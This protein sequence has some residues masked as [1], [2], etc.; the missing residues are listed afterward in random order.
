VL[1]F[2]LQRLSVQRLHRVLHR[3][4]AQSKRMSV[5]ARG[6]NAPPDEWGG[7]ALTDEQK[8]LWA[9]G[10]GARVRTLIAL[11]RAYQL[12]LLTSETARER[13]RVQPLIDIS[14]L[15]LSRGDTFRLV[16]EETRNVRAQSTVD[17]VSQLYFYFDIDQAQ[18]FGAVLRE[19]SRRG[20]QLARLRSP[21]NRNLIFEAAVRN[22]LQI[23]ANIVGVVEADVAL[24]QPRTIELDP[25]NLRG[26][27]RFALLMTLE[28][29]DAMRILWESE[30]LEREAREALLLGVTTAEQLRFALSLSETQEIAQELLDDYELAPY[31]RELVTRAELERMATDNTFRPY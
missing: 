1:F 5:A 8:A 27:S 23:L 13:A 26:P 29:Y 21:F 7:V 25:P 12:R 30:V 14:E 2:S 15:D 24:E 10:D 9:A 28:L 22:Q 6:D 19:L 11:S 3:A 20:V 17:L 18:G 31:L 4:L 16:L